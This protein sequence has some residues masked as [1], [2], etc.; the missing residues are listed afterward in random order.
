MMLFQEVAAITGDVLA[1]MPEEPSF[2]FGN[3]GHVSWNNNGY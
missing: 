2:E 1:A 3:A